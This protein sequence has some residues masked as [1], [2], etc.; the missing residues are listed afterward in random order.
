VV[1]LGLFYTGW[2]TGWEKLTSEAAASGEELAGI[3]LVRKISAIIGSA[4]SFAVLMW[5]S[6][7]GSIT[8]IVMA[9]WQRLLNLHQALDAW[10]NGIRSMVMAAVI[11]T[12]AWAIG[13]ICGD[14][15]TADYVVSLTKTFLSPH[16][17]PLLIFLSA[18]VIAFAT[19]T[20]WGTMAILMPIAIP[21]AYKFPQSDPSIDTVHA[22]A[23]LLSATA[24]V[25]AGATFGD[26]C[27]PIS[28]TTIMSSMAS[29]ADH[30]D[31]VRT[32]LPYALTAGL[33]ACLFGYIPVG[34]GLSN[35]ILLPAGALAI[36]L[37]VRF[38]G[39]KTG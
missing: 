12:A 10:V 24:A 36:L 16:W 39:R 20:S 29:S 19:G 8:A 30:I 22:T 27:S 26:H 7:I 11:L 2:D 14:L 35:W 34:F 23:I 21:L 9:V 5:A 4:D 37:I 28:D 25:L 33:V 31:H 6:F 1:S 18:G 13:D 15:F 38:A 3:S 32:Q 17:L